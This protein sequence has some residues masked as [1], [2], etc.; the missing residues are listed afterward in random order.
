MGNR[1]RGMRSC[2]F[3]PA[4]SLPY[5]GGEE[6]EIIVSGVLYLRAIRLEQKLGGSQSLYPRILRSFGLTPT[7]TQG[8]GHSALDPQC[9]KL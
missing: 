6:L 3:H 4:Q 2:H 8:Q 7:P 9:H 1:H 5:S